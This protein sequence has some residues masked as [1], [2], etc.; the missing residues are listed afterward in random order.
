MEIPVGTEIYRV[1]IGEFWFDDDGILYCNAN[2]TER[3]IENLTEAFKLVEKI[4]GGKRACLVT[5]I[6]NTGVQNKK[7]RD[8][9]TGMLPR[10]YKAMAII[11]E[12]DF[13][14]TIAN[15]FLSLYHLPIPIKLFKT[16]VEAREWIARFL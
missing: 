1:D 3:T 6:T 5:D 10:Y 7:E 9:A 13:G 15:I 14:R 4:T 2:N 12:S 11:S 8:F 16:Q